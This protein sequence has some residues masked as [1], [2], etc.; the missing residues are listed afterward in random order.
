M[1]ERAARSNRALLVMLLWLPIVF[2]S[3]LKNLLLHHNPYYPVRIAIAGHTLAGTEDPYASSPLWLRD[4]PRPLRFAASVLEIGARRL[5]DHRR[6]TVDQWAPDDAPGYR[7]GGY[8]GAYVIVHLIWMV[9][10][11]ARDRSRESNVTGLGFVALT[12]L[13]A[14]MPQSHELRYYM[15]WM[16][17][18][19]SINLWNATRRNSKE[20]LALGY[21]SS[22]ALAIVLLVTQAG[23]VY[24]SGSTFAELVREKTDE[25][26]IAGLRENAT[27]CLDKPPYNLLWA[28]AFH[29]PR[30]YLVKEAEHLQGCAAR[31]Q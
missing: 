30:H 24:P 15:A 27:V 8:F 25:R 16:I 12:A 3:P 23:Y 5:S 31:V 29:P 11:W 22:A 13:V 6:W 17:T 18:L 2:A 19:V 14:I 26:Q 28:A 7:M 1:L 10:A 9:A 20:A 4:T 21:V